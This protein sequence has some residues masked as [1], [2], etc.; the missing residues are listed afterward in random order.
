MFLLD[1]DV[2]SQRPKERPN[3]SV[4]S[5]MKGVPADNLWISSVT[6][7]ELRFGTEL[8]DA[9]K[10]RREIEAWLEQDILAGFRARIIPVDTVIA[11]TCGRLVAK[12]KRERHMPDLADALIAATAVVRG[13]TVATLNR[14]H[15]ERLGVDLVEF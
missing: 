4:M 15:F 3:V 2:L 9:G 14:T 12:A 6:I 8:L 13:L 7:E 5:W 10:R 11:D 1:T